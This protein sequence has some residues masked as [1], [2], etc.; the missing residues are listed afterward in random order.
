M[1]PHTRPHLYLLVSS[2][3]P[4]LIKASRPS[5]PAKPRRPRRPAATID[6]RSPGPSP[7]KSV[8][9]EP[10]SSVGDHD[11]R[12]AAEDRCSPSATGYGAGPIASSHPFTTYI[13][14][15]NGATLPGTAKSSTTGVVTGSNAAIQA[16]TSDISVQAGA[17]EGCRTSDGGTQ[18][19]FSS[20]SREGTA[21]EQKSG[22]RSPAA[23][24]T[25]EFEARR[26]QL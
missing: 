12:T 9:P 2:N 17:A 18:V 7:S 19:G 1:L 5:T 6:E 22:G 10:V 25:W 11:F 21:S 15:G 23:D 26:P 20:L 24:T 8:E 13:S 14:D 16:P 3:L 4:V